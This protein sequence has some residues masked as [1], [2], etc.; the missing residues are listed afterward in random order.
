MVERTSNSRA[1]ARDGL[2]YRLQNGYSLPNLILMDFAISRFDPLLQTIRSAGIHF[3]IMDEIPSTTRREKAIDIGAYDYL[4]ANIPAHALKLRIDSIMN[5]L[6]HQP[7]RPKTAI[8]E[9]I[10]MGKRLFDIAFASLVLLMLT[11]L[12]LVVIIAIRLESK[13]PVFYWQPRVGTG[14]RIFKFYKFR[15]MRVNADQMVDKMKN[16]NH[17]NQQQPEKPADVKPSNITLIG[18]NE[19]KDENEYL[20]AKKIE[21]KNSFFK[22]SND[23]RITKVGYFI[24][25][26]SI[27]ELPQLINVLKGDMSIIGNRPLPLY[28]AEK[29]TVDQWSERFKAPAGITGLWQVTERGKKDS[30]EDSRKMLDIKYAREYSFRKD[31]EILAKTPMAA[32]QQDNV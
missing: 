2:M 11:P 4:S 8:T 18:D 29:L 16:Q 30:S 1:E 20:A 13:G 6:S 32:L 23:P 5:V 19:M 22:V 9:K 25:N 28:E 24:R 27:D 26:T 15:S 3:V 10:P 31:M 7:E 17:Y 21:E 14:Y 12:F